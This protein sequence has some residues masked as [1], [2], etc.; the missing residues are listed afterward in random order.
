MKKGLQIVYNILKRDMS[1]EN[2]DEVNSETIFSDRLPRLFGSLLFI[3]CRPSS[4]LIGKEKRSGIQNLYDT[5]GEGLLLGSCVL[6]CGLGVMESFREK[7]YNTHILKVNL[8]EKTQ[9]KPPPQIGI[10]DP[11]TKAEINQFVKNAKVL[12][13]SQRGY[14][15]LFLCVP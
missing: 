1:F 8:F 4:Y 7:N 6:I 10:V 12:F 9:E 11:E 13:S 5:H 15:P 3:S 14:P 2:T